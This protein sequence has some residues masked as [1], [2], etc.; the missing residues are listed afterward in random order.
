LGTAYYSA[1]TGYNIYGPGPNGYP[2][3]LEYPAHNG[4]YPRAYVSGY[5]HANY[6]TF[7]DCMTGGT[8]GSDWCSPDSFARVAVGAYLNLGSSS[9][10]LLDC[11]PSTNPFYENNRDECYWS[12]SDFG[13]W[14]DANPTTSP[15][16]PKLAYWGF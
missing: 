14:Q 7:D 4:S 15:Y 12:G 9:T 10:H 1:H 16:G 11:V 13:G 2:S 8:L 3:N 5:K 6:D